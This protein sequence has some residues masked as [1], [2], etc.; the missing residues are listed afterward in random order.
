[1][2]KRAFV[3][4][5]FGFSC[6]S[7]WVDRLFLATRPK[8]ESKKTQTKPLDNLK[9]SF[10]KKGVKLQLKIVLTYL[11]LIFWSQTHYG[12]LY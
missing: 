10:L 5:W 4:V 7:H 9:T 6:G 8:Q 12:D 11:S 3:W 2:R 1:M